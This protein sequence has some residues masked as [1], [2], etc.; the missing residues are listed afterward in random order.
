MADVVE[1]VLARVDSIKE[2]ATYRASRERD[3]GDAAPVIKVMDHAIE[4]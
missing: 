4:N 2:D 1:E 3:R